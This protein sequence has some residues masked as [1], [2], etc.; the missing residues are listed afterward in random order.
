MNV[1]N[2]G[3]EVKQSALTILSQ[4]PN[5]HMVVIAKDKGS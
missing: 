3:E 4:H 5:A 1:L 2:L